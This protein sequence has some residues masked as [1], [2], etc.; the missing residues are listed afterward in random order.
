MPGKPASAA[1]SDDT[2]AVTLSIVEARQRR[3]SER[4]EDQG[5]LEDSVAVHEVRG[6]V[7]TT[8]PGQIDDLKAISGVAEVIEQKLN[9]LGVYTYEQIMDWDEAAVEEYS[10]LMAFKDRIQRENWVEQARRLHYE[11]QYRR[12][13]A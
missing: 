7:F 1:K 5:Q 6:K 12:R 9:D 10:K 4:S 3:D 2:H 13:A 11:N 8:P